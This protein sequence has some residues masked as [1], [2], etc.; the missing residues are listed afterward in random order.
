MQSEIELP[1]YDDVAPQAINE[2]FIPND[3]YDNNINNPDAYAAVADRESDSDDFDFST[4]S[5]DARERSGSWFSNLCSINKGQC[6]CI[7]FV[8]IFCAIWYGILTWVIYYGESLRT[9][10]NLYQ[11][12]ATQETCILTNAIEEHCTYKCRYDIFQQKNVKCSSS[13]KKS[14]CHTCNGNL[15]SYEATTVDKCSDQI[16]KESDTKSDEC[17]ETVKT[18]NTE[19]TCWVLNCSEFV[20]I[21]PDN[22]KGEGILWVVFGS[23]LMIIPCCCVCGVGYCCGSEIMR[24][25]RFSSY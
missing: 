9:E 14:S 17:P 7:L 11:D 10:G 22:L 24:Q 21:H 16:I 6:Y 23:I 2:P 19:T 1:S 5:I 3:N 8:I 15:Y 13:N 20:L 18:L 4:Y 25:I 12:Y